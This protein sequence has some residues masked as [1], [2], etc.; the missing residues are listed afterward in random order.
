MAKGLALG[1]VIN[2]YLPYVLV[3]LTLSVTLTA[4][5]A[6]KLNLY[7]HTHVLN[8]MYTIYILQIVKDV[9]VLIIF[10]FFWLLSAPL[11]FL[12]F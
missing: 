8:Y 6:P 4:Q 12:S 1:L 10:F 2:N 11:V 3:F 9:L 7:T 5:I